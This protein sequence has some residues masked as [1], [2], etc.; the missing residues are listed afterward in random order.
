MTFDS[1]SISTSP[2]S[3]NPSPRPAAPYA[4]KS[5]YFSTIVS[6]SLNAAVLLLLLFC[7][8]GTE[9]IDDGVV[10][11]VDFVRE[12]VPVPL[13]PLPDTPP[14]SAAE[15]FS[16]SPF[17]VASIAAASALR[18]ATLQP[19]FR[20]TDSQAKIIIEPASIRRTPTIYSLMSGRT[21]AERDKA[22]RQHSVEPKARSAI[23]RALRWL[24]ANQEPDG[25]WQM[26]CPSAAAT[27]LGL[28]AFLGHG[29]THES[30]EFGGTV[31]A[32][33]R[34]LL[35]LQQA[36]GQF[37][38]TGGHQVYGHAIA[39]YALCEAAGMTRIIEIREAARAA[40]TRIINGQQAGGGWG[41][42]YAPTRSD[43]SVIGWQVQALKAAHLA[44][45]NIP[46]LEDSL[47]RAAEGMKQHASPTGGFGYTGPG[48]SALTAAGTLTLQ[49]LGHARAPEAQRGL[50]ILSDWACN[51]DTPQPQ[52]PLYHWYYCTQARFQGGGE[53]WKSWDR[54]LQSQLT[55]NQ[56][57][58]G[59]AREGKVGHWIGPAGKQEGPGPVYSTTLCTL[60]L[61]VYIRYLPT[62]R[63]SQDAATVHE[64]LLQDDVRITVV[65]SI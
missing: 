54:Q 22:F 31:E 9:L 25:R 63:A 57:V 24:K 42:D 65:D 30:N 62:Y 46:G 52:R 4:I 11:A 20:P 13:D 15:I 55:R 27:G 1:H 18:V 32:A 28:L 40:A 64:S 33:M 7:I 48:N 36:D 59:S 56:V 34:Y 38:D 44:R 21:A 35:D 50:D 8:A 17:P 37:R 3:D 43:A 61:E 12:P 19:V 41:Y 6:L 14:P 53:A 26:G 29:E 58:S 2:H 23:L 47:A 60:M 16:S 5:R 45:L 39:T 49:L 51:W 10:T